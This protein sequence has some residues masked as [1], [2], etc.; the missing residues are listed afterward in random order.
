[1]KKRVWIMNHYASSMFFDGGGRHYWFA[2][3]LRR[4]GYEP[5]IFCCNSR[6][7]KDNARWFDTDALWEEHLAEDIETPFVF[8]R[9]RVYTGNGKQRVLNMADF[10]R[11]VQKAAKEYAKLHGKP[12]VILASSV[13]PLTIVAGIR[14]AKRFGVRC[15]GEVRDL[16]PESIVEYSPRFTSD[17]LLIKALYRG[18]KWIYTHADEMI[19]TMEGAYDYIV[20]RGWER[21]VPRERVHYIN[22]GVDLEVF[23]RNRAEYRVEDAELNDPNTF[24]VV[25]AGAI[26]MANNL[27][28]LL[29]AAKLLQNP[30]VR[31]LIWGDGDELPALQKRVAQEHIDKVSFRGRV[32]KKYIPSVVSR[33]DVNVINYLEKD[34]SRYG[35]SFNKMFEYLAAGRPVFSAERMPYSIL[36]R[37]RCGTEAEKAAP[38]ILAAR[39]D[40]FAAMPETERAEMGA[41]ARAAA[42][43]FDFRKLT[44]RLID[45]IE[46]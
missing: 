41:R 21:A 40:A 4:A 19:F 26:R 35:E 12:D 33:A 14:L 6:H 44:E 46:R 7:N 10:Y 27:G 32:E 11:N 15:I 42:A 29:D 2:K 34:V 28:I 3:Y 13:H 9:G 24:K 31:L 38:E 37:Y 1:M 22:N 23:D 18:E 25:Y 8:V 45:L 39:I 30:N 20:E 36:K 17:N 5:V 16:W 43:D